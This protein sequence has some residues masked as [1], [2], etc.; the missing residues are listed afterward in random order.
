MQTKIP[1]HV[2]CTKIP[3]HVICTKTHCDNK[4]S[5]SHAGSEM[6]EC[7]LLTWT[8]HFKA[9]TPLLWPLQG[10]FIKYGA[11]ACD[12]YV[13]QAFYFFNFFLI[14]AIPF[15]STIYIH[16]LYCLKHNICIS[17]HWWNINYIRAW[18]NWYFIFWLVTALVTAVTCNRWHNSQSIKCC[19]GD[20]LMCNG[21]DTRKLVPQWR[22]YTVYSRI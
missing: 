18:C 4:P 9:L 6:L 13:Q 7:A 5:L 14:V 19:W 12:F 3:G 17:M 22:L 20:K 11:L 10:N 8:E 1:G 16:V 21:N 2:I 15:C